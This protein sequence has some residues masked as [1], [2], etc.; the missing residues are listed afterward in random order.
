MIRIRG[1]EKTYGAGEAARE[2]LHGLDLD[3]ADGEMI[4]VEGVSGCGKTTLLNLIGGLDRDY[5]GTIEVAGRDLASLRE[6]DLASF[7]N[8]KVGFVFQHFHLLDHLTLAENVSLPAFFS[9]GG[10]DPGARRN[11]ATEVLDR[12]GLADRVDD[13]PTRLSGGQKQRV[14]I[15]RALFNRPDLI[16]CDEP[17]GNLDTETGQHVLD[18]FTS[19]NQD[20]GITLV[21]VT[22][23]HRVSMA[24]RRVIRL[25]DGVIVSDSRAP[26]GVR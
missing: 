13:L 23:E 8:S 6:P 2:V 11:R 7:R 9:K 22:H 15:A 4:S 16:L 26:G 24:A 17:T 19:L 14:A 18:L 12:V 10:S 21:L 3:V 5:R 25:E 1:L 20:E